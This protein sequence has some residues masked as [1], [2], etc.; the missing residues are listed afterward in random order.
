MM[1]LIS[2]HNLPELY[3][4]ATDYIVIHQ[5]KIKKTMTLEEL[6]ESCQHHILI[7][8]DAPE[9]LA[10]VLET[11]LQTT[12]YKVMPDRTIKLYDYLDEKEKVSRIL[13][14]NKILVTNLSNEGDTLEGYFISIV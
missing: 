9:R 13:F 10:E 11:K 3:Q 7:K 5:G 4:T 12:N 2:S 1:I 8:S 6:D 14:E